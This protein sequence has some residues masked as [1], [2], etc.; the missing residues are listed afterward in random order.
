[1]SESGEKL[2][3]LDVPFKFL[4]G[5]SGYHKGLASKS[6]NLQDVF[7]VLATADDNQEVKIMDGDHDDS[8]S[9]SSSSSDDEADGEK[10]NDNGKRGAIDQIKDYSKHS[11]QLKRSQRGAM[12]FK[13]VRTADWMK[14]KLQHGKARMTGHFQHHEREPGVETEV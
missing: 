1:M 10:E 14:T 6:P 8:G 13:G 12:Q 7:E 9:S 11:D 2:G 5:L 3:H 4:R